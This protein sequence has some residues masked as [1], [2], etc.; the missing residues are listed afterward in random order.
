MTDLYFH[1]YAN[2]PFAEK[3][4]RI[5]AYKQL[6]W[7][8]V[9]QPPMMPK[10]DLVALTGGYRRIPVMQIGADIICD[11]ALICEVLETLK[12]TPSIFAQPNA[13]AARTIAGWA[14]STLFSVAMAFNFGPKGASAF[15]A[16]MPAEFA[17]AFI[18]DRKAMRLGAA[19]MHP[20][21][22]TSAYRVYLARVNDMTANGFACG[23]E[24]SIADFAIYHTGRLSKHPCLD[25]ASCSVG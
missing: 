17:N 14:D 8:S 15:F 16:K 10:P 11:T 5:L 21:D 7:L 1:H 24:P 20:A 22:A 18:E 12:P 13:A 4:R 25:A 9:L 2:S 19:R 23:A 3:I 6:P